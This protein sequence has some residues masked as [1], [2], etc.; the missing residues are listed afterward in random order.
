[1]TGSHSGVGDDFESPRGTLIKGVARM[2]GLC[3][4]GEGLDLPPLRSAPLRENGADI[5]L[6]PGMPARWRD[7]RGACPGR[8][9]GAPSFDQGGGRSFMLGFGNAGGGRLRPSCSLRQH[10]GPSAP[11]PS[12]GRPSEECVTGS[13]EERLRARHPSRRHRQ[14]LAQASRSCVEGWHYQFA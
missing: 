3:R 6:P 2:G 11:A 10:R 7:A 13:K 12:R 14:F 9:A 4:P 5:S 8:R 1:M